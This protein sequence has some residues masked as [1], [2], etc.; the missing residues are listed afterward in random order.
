M[1]RKI[2]YQR[3]LDVLTY[4]KSHTYIDTAMHF[5]ISEMTISRIKK[6][7]NGKV[8]VSDLNNV[9]VSDKVSVSE[10]EK[11][12][13]PIADNN[14]FEDQ[15]VSVSDKVSVSET[16]NFSLPEHIKIAWKDL[17]PSISSVFSKRKWPTKHKMFTIFDNWINKLLTN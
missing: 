12:S 4:L 13:T 7:D 16:N 10:H 3:D 6:R 14:S 17:A 15:K 9:S 8:S 1:P 11:D 2:D 5:N